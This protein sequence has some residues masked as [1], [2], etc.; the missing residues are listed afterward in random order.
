MSP[1]TSTSPVT[2]RSPVT[3]KF[4]NLPVECNS[5]PIVVPLMEPPLISVVVRTE[6]FIVIIPVERA[7]VAEAV[8]S[9]ALILSTSTVSKLLEP[10]DVISP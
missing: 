8:P 1:V 3:S 6:L 5:A 2:S 10:I 9:P 7:I 4:V